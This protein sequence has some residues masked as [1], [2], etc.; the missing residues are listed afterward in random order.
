MAHGE[1]DF[2]RP[3]VAAG[4]VYRD[5][6][7]RVLLVKPTYKAGWDLPGGYVEQ[8]ETPKAAAAREV[9]EELGVRLPVGRLLVVDWAP[10]P[11]EGDKILFVFDGGVLSP[12]M[13]RFTLPADEIADARFVASSEFDDRLPDRLLRRVAAAVREPS[14]SYLEDGLTER[15]GGQTPAAG[16][17]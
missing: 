7:A 5:A 15:S 10:H 1:P 2:V 6:S 14:D 3:R 9:V 8:G 12:S 11:A 16:H 13:A 17:H 4:V